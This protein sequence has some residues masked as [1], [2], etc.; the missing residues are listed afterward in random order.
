MNDAL[1]NVTTAG[2]ETFDL[3]RLQPGVPFEHA[4]SQLSVL[5]G[6]IRH[7]TTEAEMEHDR[8]AGSAARILSEMAKALIDDIELG[9][10]KSH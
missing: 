2:S 8:Q 6:C 10:N 4:F 9:L 7:L 3:F 5:L 1:K